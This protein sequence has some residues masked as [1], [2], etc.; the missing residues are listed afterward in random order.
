MLKLV[1]VS[2]KYLPAVVKVLGEYKKDP[3]PY[4][5]A[6]IK[7]LIEA[8]DQNKALEWIQKMQNEEK[9]INLKPGYVS[10]TSY[11]LMEGEEY[12]G[13]F[14]LRHSLTENLLK[15]GGHIAYIIRPSKRRQGYASAGLRLCLQEAKKRG[16]DRALITCN[17]KNE[18]SFAVITKA[19]N[20]FGGEILPDIKIDDGFE[21]RV[22][23]NT[24]T[25]SS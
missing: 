7:S 12:I 14:Q 15:I 9:G 6:D 16:I 11:W 25:K 17:T 2:E 10:A 20:K 4:M 22:W 8:V 3:S 19:M 13:S 23:V 5:V 1:K 18:A 21:H 24:T